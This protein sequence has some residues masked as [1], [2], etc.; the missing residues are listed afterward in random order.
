MLG[1]GSPGA[2]HS[3]LHQCQPEPT[4]GRKS[5]EGQ[6]EKRTDPRGSV[7]EN[8]QGLRS[9]GSACRNR[10]LNI[11]TVQFFLKFLILHCIYYC[12]SFRSCEGTSPPPLL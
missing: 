12:S 2:A 5:A 4:G 9:G 3:S 8:L 1:H 6:S 11:R 7:T 10:S